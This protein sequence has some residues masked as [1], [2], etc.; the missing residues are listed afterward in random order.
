LDNEAFDDVLVSLN[1][2]NK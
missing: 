2:I 1:L